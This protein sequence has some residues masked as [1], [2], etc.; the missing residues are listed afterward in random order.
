MS[1]QEICPMTAL[2][3]SVD[4][5]GEASESKIEAAENAFKARLYECI[6]QYGLSVREA[7]A[8]ILE[9]MGYGQTESAEILSEIECRPISPQNVN[10]Y[11]RRAR[12][13]I[14]IAVTPAE[15]KE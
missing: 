10:T 4:T 3:G 1:E 7:Q 11:L 14:N 9:D 6:S 15:D 5:S 2:V 8:V 13:K 12:L